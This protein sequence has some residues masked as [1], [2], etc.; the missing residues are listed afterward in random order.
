MSTL[1][2]ISDTLRK[3]IEELELKIEGVGKMKGSERQ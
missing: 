1:E 3:Q 2:E